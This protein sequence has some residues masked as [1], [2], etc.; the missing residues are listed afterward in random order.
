MR[1]SARARRDCDAPRRSQRLGSERRRIER[2]GNE[3]RGRVFGRRDALR[4]LARRV[5]QIDGRDNGRARTML[6]AAIARV[7]TC[8]RVLVA[9]VVVMRVRGLAAGRAV[10]MQRAEADRHHGERAQR[11]DREQEQHDERSDV[12]AHAHR[13]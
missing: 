13:C 11:H 1:A 5:R 6:D 8:A 4:A 2:V 7:V 10:L 9:T 12:V 3:A